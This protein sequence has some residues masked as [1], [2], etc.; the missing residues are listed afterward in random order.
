M[1][2][3]SLL[4]PYTEMGAE[5][6]ST[7]KSRLVGSTDLGWRFKDNY[8]FGSYISRAG[9]VGYGLGT[10][11]QGAASFITDWKDMPYAESENSKIIVEMGLIGFLII[12]LLRLSIFYYSYRVFNMTKIYS[13]KL[14]LAVFLIIQIP[15]VLAFNNVIYVYMEN[16]IYWLIIG[17]VVSINRINYNDRRLRIANDQR[18]VQQRYA[19]FSM[20]KYGQ[21]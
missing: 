6:Y 4:I 7:F 11:Y 1:V 20:G 21:L 10:T 8:N 2:L 13:L 9:I 17:I 19:N 3:G 18:Y 15:T 5:A 12:N 14:L 16:L